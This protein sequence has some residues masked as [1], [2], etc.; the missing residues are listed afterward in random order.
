MVIYEYFTCDARGVFLL[1]G[2]G[3]VI[4][5]IIGALLVYGGYKMMQRKKKVKKMRFQINKN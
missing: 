1:C 2:I 3:G 5:L 4:S